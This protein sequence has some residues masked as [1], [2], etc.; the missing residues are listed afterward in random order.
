MTLWLWIKA[1][2]KRIWSARGAASSTAAF[3]TLLAT[4]VVNR[5]WLASFPQYDFMQ[6]AVFGFAM[7]MAGFVFI[8]TEVVTL[9]LAGLLGDKN[10]A[11]ANARVSAAE[12]E[13][14]RAVAAKAEAEAKVARVEAAFANERSAR[15][16]AEAKV[17]KNGASLEEN[18]F[19]R[20]LLQRFEDE[21]EKERV[22][23]EK[24]REII[25]ELLSQRA[26]K[27][28]RNGEDQPSAA[29]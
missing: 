20:E 7:N 14:A 8:G 29:P 18:A 19:I 13:A 11:E 12:A 4:A 17:G 1:A 23:R 21:R 22:E 2:I 25:R 26:D 10:K 28:G 15:I 9:I 6:I 3:L 24:D 27:R 16:E 5:E